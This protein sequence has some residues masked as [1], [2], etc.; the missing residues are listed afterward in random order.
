MYIQIVKAQSKGVCCFMS[1]YRIKG[2]SKVEG[3]VSI[4]GSKNSSLP[5]IAACILNGGIT[6][7][8]NVPDIRDTNGM[9]VAEYRTNDR[10]SVGIEKTGYYH[11][12][13]RVTF[14]DP[15]VYHAHV[16]E[17][18]KSKSSGV[19]SSSNE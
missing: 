8:Y 13:D 5:I 1:V 6:Q 7:L 14:S 9:F 18:S 2:G 12:F 16:S 19:L 10:L 4:S 3:E 11:T 17:S 15:F